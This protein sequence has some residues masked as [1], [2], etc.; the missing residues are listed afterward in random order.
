[1]RSIDEEY[2]QEI[3]EIIKMILDKYSI[4]Y[5]EISGSI[6]DRKNILYTLI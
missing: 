5:I 6:D 2:R 4:D 3:D 1:M